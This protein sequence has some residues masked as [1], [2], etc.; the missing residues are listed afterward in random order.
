MRHMKH[1]LQSGP[2]HTRPLAYNYLQ[3]RIMSGKWAART[4]KIVRHLVLEAP[5]ILKMAP[6]FYY[7]APD[8]THLDE[9]APYEWI[10]CILRSFLPLKPSKNRMW[11]RLFTQ[12]NLAVR[13]LNHLF[14]GRVW[15]WT[16]STSQNH[17]PCPKSEIFPT[18]SQMWKNFFLQQAQ[19]GIFLPP[20]YA[21]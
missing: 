12:N 2:L 15:N 13:S 5:F 7:S 21:I 10:W 4:M 11:W 19:I 16:I 14:L 20:E 18:S 1:V 17:T 8:S 9:A 3:L 6:L